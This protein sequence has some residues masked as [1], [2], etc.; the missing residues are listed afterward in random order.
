MKKKADK[1]KDVEALRKALESAP[2]VFVAGFEKLTVSQ[3]FDLRKTVRGA[4]G[5]YRVIK[6]NL[7]EKA[8]EGTPAEPL[9]KGLAGM[10]SLAFTS[11][12]PVA[13]AK[14]LTTYAKTNPS[15]T[16]KA[17]MV[18][19]RAIDVRSIQELA[20]MPSRNELLA[21]VL[22]LIQSPA[23]RLAVAINALGRNLAVVID[24]AAKENKFQQ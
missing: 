9:M 24:Q 1:I 18:E 16:F 19:G 5:H 23:Q 4:G 8:S 7:A 17:G 14:A 10:T 13:L 22:F 2:S 11:G 21:K 15:L 20:S 12:D 6:N 3:D